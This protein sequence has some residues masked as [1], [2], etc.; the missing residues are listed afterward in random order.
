MQK[1]LYICDKCG[2]QSTADSFLY[3]VHVQNYTARIEDNY[4]LC[5]TCFSD[6][7]HLL[8]HNWIVIDPDNLIYNKEDEE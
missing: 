1:H 4:D 5:P 6:L 3:S 2:A 7:V 8:Q